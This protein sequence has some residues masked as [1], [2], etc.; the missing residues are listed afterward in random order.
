MDQFSFALSIRHADSLTKTLV[1]DMHTRWEISS[2][3][4][5]AAVLF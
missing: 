2:W 5:P 3:P 4:L 1:A